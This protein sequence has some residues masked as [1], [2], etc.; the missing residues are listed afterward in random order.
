[1][2][3]LFIGDVNGRTGR[4][5]V[6]EHLDRLIDRHSIDYAVANVENAAD[7]FGVTPALAAELEGCGLHVMTSGNHIW[8][9]AEIL[10]Y[11]EEHRSLLRPHNYPAGAPG[12]GVH[13]GATAAG[14]PVA[15]INLM[16]RVFMNALDCPF[17]TADRVLAE[18]ASQARVILVD[19]H[20]E[21]TS[22][23]VAMGWYLDGRVSA[24]LGTHTH[25]QTADERVLPQ[26]T[27]VITDAG[28]TGAR[29]SVI[30][31]E[32]ELALRRFLQ[33]M[34]VRFV[35]ARKNPRLC[36]VVV[37]VDEATG[38]A[39][40]IQRLDLPGSAGAE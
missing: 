5:L 11:I 4:N 37:D 14:I 18:I 33:Q 21:A 6:R 22:E 25:V 34:P 35:C 12:T 40:G 16:G 28:M 20:A 2:N 39:R 26:G 13:L 19:F 30:G 1:M 32:K 36:A 24:V 29:D 9:K 17:R 10:P 3:L 7:G 31:V 27:A 15:V 23:K 38:R 8:D